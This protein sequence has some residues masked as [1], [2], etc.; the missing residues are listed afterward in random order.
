MP[1]QKSAINGLYIVTWEQLEDPRGFFL[2]TYQF[3]EIS[4]VLGRNLRLRQGNHSRSRPRV[5]RGFHKEMWDKLVYV[6]R[7]HALCVVADTRPESPTFGTTLSFA[8]GDPPHGQRVRLFIS[9]GLANAIYCPVETDY[10]NDVSEEFE[11]SR[12]SGVIW[13]DPTL[14]VPWPDQQPILSATDSAHPTLKETFPSHPL[15]FR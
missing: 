12:R 4:R 9:E 3:G 15:F 11:P 8:L 14:A 2:Q 5:L 13:N 10:L 7:G 1:V 6:V